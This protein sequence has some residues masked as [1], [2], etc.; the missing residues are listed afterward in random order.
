MAH[1]SRLSEEVILWASEEFAFIQL[2]DR[3]ATGSSLMPQKKNP[4]VP[5]LVRGKSGEFLDIY[6]QCLP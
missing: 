2:T 3:C 5:E 4:D 1:L 6:K